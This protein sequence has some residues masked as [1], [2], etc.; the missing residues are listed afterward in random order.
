MTLAIK[1]VAGLLAL[2]SAAA[3]LWF[4]RESN[5]VSALRGTLDNWQ[6]RADQGEIALNDLWTT[7]LKAAENLQA[8]VSSAGD[9]TSRDQACQFIDLNRNYAGT[10]GHEYNPGDNSHIDLRAIVTALNHIQDDTKSR[11]DALRAERDTV[12]EEV[13]TQRKAVAAH[14]SKIY[15]ASLVAQA[16]G[17]LAILMSLGADIFGKD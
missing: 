11:R 6:R 3:L 9:Q 4:Y 10:W 5:K 13:A 12:V 7:S 17:V 16:L 14:E 8:L 1:V 2:A 15:R